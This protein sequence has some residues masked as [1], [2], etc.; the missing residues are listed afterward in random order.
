MS[1]PVRTITFHASLDGVTPTARQDAGIQGEHNATQVV[2]ALDD[3][4][5]KPTYLYRFEYV[6][7]GGG[8]DTTDH[9][10]LVE[11]SLSVFL[12]MAWTAAGGCGVIRLQISEL[13]ADNNEEF[14]LYTFTGRLLFADRDTGEPMSAEYEKGLSGLIEDVHDAIDKA[15]AA[16]IEV[17][18]VTTGGPGTDAAVTNTGT[19]TDA[20]LNFVIPRGDKGEKGDTGEQG[21]Q[22][23]K[24]DAG[25]AGPQGE[26]GP[27]G[28]QGPKGD[29]GDTGPQGIKGDTG[30]TGP[31][32]PKGEPG[33]DGVA[34][35]TDLSP[36]LFGLSVN[37]EGH[38]ILTHNDNEPAPPLSIQDGKLIYTIS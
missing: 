38:L 33:E 22:G 17:G 27:T 28:P 23:E 1:D 14:I 25:P 4:L 6:D 29:T 30:A 5:I 2:F 13:D 19:E 18:T 32:G 16:T 11:S 37:A 21:P 31:Q 26:A 12:P 3:T 10:T 20:V 24:G 8:W 36:G 15:K 7:G 9:I 35:I 34:A